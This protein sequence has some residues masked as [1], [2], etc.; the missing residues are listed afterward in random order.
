[1]A[2]SYVKNLEDTLKITTFVREVKERTERIDIMRDRLIELL[3]NAFVK[4]DDNY[5]MPNSSQVAD[6]LLDNGV[7]VPPCKVGDKV[8][9][10]LK[11]TRFGYI[12]A[13]PKL[14]EAD[15]IS[16]RL[17]TNKRFIWCA[18]YEEIG[19]DYSIHKEV[20]SFKLSDIGTTAFLTREEAE[21]ALEENNADKKEYMRPVR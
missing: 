1:M 20:K 21:K 6:Y 12:L 19:Y 3:D 2:M 8:Y 11:K 5:G 9:L 15:I 16:I 17:Y 13:K 10:I 7:I 18:E 14:V 4:C